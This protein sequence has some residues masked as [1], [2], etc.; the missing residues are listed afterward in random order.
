MQDFYLNVAKS[1]LYSELATDMTKFV[2]TMIYIEDYSAYLNHFLKYYVNWSNSGHTNTENIS[3]CY[4]DAM[5]SLFKENGSEIKSQPIINDV[6]PLYFKGE[7]NTVY[8]QVQNTVQNDTEIIMGH[9]ESLVAVLNTT[10]H[11]YRCWHCNKKGYF[12]MDCWVKKEGKPPTEDSKY[13]KMKKNLSN[14]KEEDKSLS[15][16]VPNN[17]VLPDQFVKSTSNQESKTEFAVNQ[18]GMVPKI[19]KD[20]EAKRLEDGMTTFIKSKS[21]EIR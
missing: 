9:I 20:E 7:E 1:L 21:K 17:W 15:S 10:S 5:V 19:S 3:S 16:S 18:V 14:D 12:M 2:D 6:E 8:E 11:S 13:G 4:S